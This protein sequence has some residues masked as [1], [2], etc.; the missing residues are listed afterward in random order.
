MEQAI[1]SLRFTDENG[2]RIFFEVS[3]V[4]DEEDFQKRKK[5]NMS[6]GLRRAQIQDVDAMLDHGRKKWFFIRHCGLQVIPIPVDVESFCEKYQNIK[7]LEQPH[8]PVFDRWTV[9]GLRKNLGTRRG[10]DDNFS[11]TFQFV[12]GLTPKGGGQR[13]N[14]IVGG[15]AL[16]FLCDSS[17]HTKKMYL[18]GSHL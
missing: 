9:G 18:D 2:K 3:P 4:V 17:E 6:V 14:V 11:T 7:R 12:K 10:D 5:R 1:R 13:K 15:Y 16:V 8:I